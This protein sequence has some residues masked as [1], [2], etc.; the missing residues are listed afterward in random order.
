MGWDRWDELI[1][2]ATGPDDSRIA[3][4]ISR[5]ESQRPADAAHQPPSF[6]SFSQQ[7]TAF[8]NLGHNA[9]NQQQPEPDDT[10][11]KIPFDDTYPGVRSPRGGRRRRA[12]QPEQPDTQSGASTPTRHH[13]STSSLPNRDYILSLADPDYILQD[14]HQNRVPK[15]PATF[16]CTLCDKRFSRAYNLRSHLRTHTDERP[17]ACTVCGKAFAKQH[18]R[19]RHE[20]LHSGEKKFVCMGELKGGSNWGC[21]RRFARADQLGRHLRSESGLSTCIKP[22]LEEEAIEQERQNR[23]LQEPQVQ[24]ST[25]HQQPI[26]DSHFKPNDRI[27]HTRTSGWLPAALLAQYPALATTELPELPSELFDRIV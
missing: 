27:F 7:P 11:A 4:E 13:Q 9:E 25:Q 8:S 17:F 1:K 6:D 12:I 22:L 2:T 3:S 5:S 14:D 10:T 23:L 20:G 16:K 26:H 18:D 21:G 24:N 15:H 19:K